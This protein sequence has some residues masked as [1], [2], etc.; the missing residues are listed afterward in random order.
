MTSDVF[1]ALCPVGTPVLAYPETRDQRPFRTRTTSRAW[2]VQ[3]GLPVVHVDG[4][5]DAVL[6]THIDPL[7]ET[8]P[9][10]AIR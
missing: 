5:T 3:H 1:N 2:D 6:L 8:A 7:P 9:K 10:E 4:I